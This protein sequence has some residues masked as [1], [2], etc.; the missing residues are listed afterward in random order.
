LENKVDK[1]ALLEA[2]AENA[3]QWEDIK[4]NNQSRQSIRFIERDLEDLQKDFEQHINKN[5]K[6]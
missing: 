4:A 1:S 5:H 6:G 3:R 2:L